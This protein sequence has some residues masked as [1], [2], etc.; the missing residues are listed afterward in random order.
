MWMIKSVNQK[1][2]LCICRFTCRKSP[3][4]TQPLVV[5][6]CVPHPVALGLLMHLLLC[7]TLQW[8]CGNGGEWALTWQ[9]WFG[10]GIFS[11]LFGRRCQTMGNSHSCQF[12]QQFLKSFGM[13]SPA[14]IVSIS[15]SWL[16]PW[17]W[18]Y[19]QMWVPYYLQNGLSVWL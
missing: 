10:A 8:D 2:H 3:F 18:K 7:V 12:I 13:C 17:S 11:S 4:D 14:S 19:L 15:C 16:K 5:V 9:R 1:A 6:L